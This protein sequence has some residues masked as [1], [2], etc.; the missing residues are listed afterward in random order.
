MDPYLHAGTAAPNP[1]ATP[2]ATVPTV[3]MARTE[4]ETPTPRQGPKMPRQGIKEASK[5]PAATSLVRGP[6]L[7]AKLESARTNAL[8]PF[9]GAGQASES[10]NAAQPLLSEGPGPPS[11]TATVLQDDDTDEELDRAATSPG[12]TRLE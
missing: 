12:L 4:L 6:G 10:G 1:G 5:T 9:H 8:R 2:A 3:P 7:G 11:A